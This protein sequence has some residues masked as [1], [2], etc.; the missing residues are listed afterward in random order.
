MGCSQTLSPPIFT[1]QVAQVENKLLFC[2]HDAL[3]Q[4]PLQA[5][6][7]A[8]LL[9]E[10]KQ[11]VVAEE[12][13]LD[14]LLRTAKDNTDVLQDHGLEVRD[15]FCGKATNF[16]ES[17]QVVEIGRLEL[18]I[19]RPLGVFVEN[20]LGERCRDAQW[21]RV[22]HVS[23]V[24]STIEEEARKVAHQQVRQCRCRCFLQQG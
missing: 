23:I 9:T 17:F 6:V 24:V 8:Q 15:R 3:L 18:F 13:L 21:L 11:V 5:F 7:K 19:D 10:G 2:S 1:I 16:N 20:L 14:Q 22:Q 4:F 12:S